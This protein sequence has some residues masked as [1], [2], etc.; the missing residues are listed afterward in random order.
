M[1]ALLTDSL[2]TAYAEKYEGK[3]HMDCP[4]PSLK[5][6]CCP[7][8]ISQI[9]S[10]PLDHPLG[11]SI[12]LR[13]A[14]VASEGRGSPFQTAPRLPAAYVIP[15]HSDPALT[16]PCSCLAAPCLLPTSSLLPLSY[17]EAWLG[18]DLDMLG[19]HGL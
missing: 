5:S 3:G 10:P 6:L 19:L 13:A 15:V 2:A 11:T 14:L 4:P 12:R 18:L 17:R 7:C 8:F 1:P 16:G 9:P